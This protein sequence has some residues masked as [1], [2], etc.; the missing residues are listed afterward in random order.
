MEYSKGI[1]Q[2]VV[3]CNVAEGL[4]ILEVYDYKI[5]VKYIDKIIWSKSFE[6]KI[7]SCRKVLGNFSSISQQIE[8][9]LE[10]GVILNYST[11]GNLLHNNQN[12]IG[13]FDYL[14]EEFSAMT[15]ASIDCGEGYFKVRLKV[16]S[17]GEFEL[18]DT[19][20]MCV[21]QGKDKEIVFETCIFNYELLQV[22]SRDSIEVQ[23]IVVSRIKALSITYIIG[24]STLTN[25]KLPFWGWPQLLQAKTKHICV[26]YAISARSTKSFELEGRLDKLYNNLKRGDKLIIGF[27]HNDEKENY[28][29]TEVK[30]Y[31]CNLKKIK[32][33]CESIG[34]KTYI[35]TP[36]ARRN[37]L[38]SRLKD[39]H[40]E[41]LNELYINFPNNILDTNLISRQLINKY[42]REE[43]K[44]L[45]VHCDMLKVYDNT[46]T[47]YLGAAE[48]CKMVLDI[49]KNAL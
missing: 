8:I 20:G 10:T 3:Q 4:Y 40:I 19:R 37:F 43:S 26:N 17:D 25:Q 21:Y 32:E 24:D 31:I 49:Y 45:F 27:G 13:K 9:K 46:H 2:L 5:E 41:Y 47:S 7:N 38:D 39:T 35:A 48:I 23:E 29:G 16:E 42:G 34:V 28:F 11:T 30:E 22:K 15:L 36:I 18:F 44:Q 6:K 12:P 14:E 1:N 33:K